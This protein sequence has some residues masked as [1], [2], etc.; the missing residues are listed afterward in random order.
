MLGYE[1]QFAIARIE[2]PGIPPGIVLEQ[3]IGWHRFP[4][5]ELI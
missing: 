4:V 5:R 2:K 3:P 1:K